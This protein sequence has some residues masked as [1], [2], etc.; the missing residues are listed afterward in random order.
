MNEKRERDAAHEDTQMK[1][2]CECFRG[3]CASN[4]QITL[5]AYETVRA[6]G[7]SFI[8]APGHQSNDD[9]AQRPYDPRLGAAEAGAS[10][11]LQNQSGVATPRLLGSTP[12]SHRTSLYAD[13]SSTER[14]FPA[15]SLNH[16]M[17]GPPLPR[18]MPRSSCSIPS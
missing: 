2:E 13:S 14:M 15:G 3:E 9:P 17:F 6:N 16:A 7:R 11:G 8:V 4:F 18:A 10:T 12:G 1:C 5:D